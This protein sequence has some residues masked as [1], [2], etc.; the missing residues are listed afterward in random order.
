MP[1]EAVSVKRLKN[2]YNMH[3]YTLQTNRRLT[4]A[5]RRAPGR[6]VRFVNSRTYPYASACVKHVAIAVRAIL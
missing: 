2:F 6:E 3:T 5:A 1:F 4:G